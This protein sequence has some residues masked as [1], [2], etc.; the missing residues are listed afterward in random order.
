MPFPGFLRLPLLLAAAWGAESPVLMAQPTGSPA[1]PAATTGLSLPALPPRPESHIL[2][3]SGMLPEA[4]R[5]SLS[6]R[7]LSSQ[8][9]TGLGLYL[10]IHTY[11]REET[12]DLRASRFHSLWLE[13]PAAGIVVVH[14]RSTGR[15]SFAGSNNP[16]LPEAGSLRALYRLSDAA[17]KSL[18]PEATGADRIVSTLT[19]LADGL[20]SWQKN[21]RLPAA[22]TAAPPA[23]PGPAAK[24]A[25]LHA[26]PPF[27]RPDTFLV[28]EAGVFTDPAAASGLSRRLEALYQEH[29][30]RLYVVTVTYP[31]PGLSLPLSEKLALEWLPDTMGGVI[32]FDRSQP[33]T[34]S[35]GGTQHVDRWL[36]PLQLQSLHEGALAAARASGDKP[37]AWIPA[38]ANHLI[39]AYVRDGLP[40]FKDSARWLPQTQR[41]IFPLV[42]IGFITT[43]GLLYLLQRW[44]ERADR[45]RRTVFRFPEVYVPERLGAPH[46]GGLTAES[47][48]PAAV[49]ASA[50]VPSR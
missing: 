31:P 24:P 49:S 5:K 20:E 9:R 1:P 14:D 27:L 26:R 47:A 12:A 13:E 45:R 44:Q 23:S 39:S 6:T 15:V 36:S 33:D 7:L 37:H 50:T 4:V 38:A 8:T 34:L 18:P 42:L 19:A 32:V 3:E 16:R 25:G 10:A 48:L 35:F 30:L 46:G 41:R 11:L 21:G 40:I 17:A 29:G 2:D 43:A 22:P 28:D